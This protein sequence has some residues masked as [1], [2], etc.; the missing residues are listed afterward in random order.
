MTANEIVK[1]LR[2]RSRRPRQHALWMMA[3]YS[4]R[5]RGY[6]ISHTACAFGIHRDMVPY[7]IQKVNDLIDTNDK[8]I[9][10][11]KEILGTHIIDLVPYF[12]NNTKKIKTYV[13]IDNKKL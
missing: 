7:T 8:F 3:I 10:N 12:D 5:K 4:I 11:A 9:L 6:S 2:T 1:S 13:K